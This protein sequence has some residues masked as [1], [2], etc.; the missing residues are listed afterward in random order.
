MR[1]AKAALEGSL[2]KYPSNIMVL[3]TSNRRYPVGSR[4]T[5]STEEKMAFTN[6]YVSACITCGADRESNFCAVC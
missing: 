4:S 1:S 5:D 2:R 6:R 3:I